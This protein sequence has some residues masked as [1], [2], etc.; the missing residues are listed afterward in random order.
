MPNGLILAAPAS[1][2]GKTVVALALAAALRR[3][4]KRVVPAKSGPDYIDGA[5]LAAAA[6]APCRNLDAWAMRR[7]TIAATLAA[8]GDA[9]LVLCEGAMGLFDGIGAGSIGS[10]AALAG[11]V[12]WPVVL[13]ADAA[14]VG[15]SISALVQGFAR[16]RPETR[17]GGIIL[18]RVGSA[19]HRAALEAALARDVPE[20]AYLGAL[21]R[22]AA[23]ALPSRHLG[24]V[25]ASELEALDTLIARAAEK[26]EAELDVARILALAAPATLAPEKTAPPLPPP[27]QRIAVA[28]DRAFAFAYAFVLEGWRAAGASLAFF[29][30]LADEPPD[31]ACDAVYLPGGYPELHAGTLAAARRC[32]AGLHAAAAHGARIYGECGGYMAL[33]RGLVDAAGARHEM[34]GL[35][36]LETD[37]S[38]RR[39]QLGYREARLLASSPFGAAGARYRGHE[40]HYATVREEGAGDALFALAD[41]EG[42]PLGAA[43]RVAG[44]V[45][46]S[47]VHLLD[48]A[49]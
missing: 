13:V 2:S 18:N 20:V 29:S 5:F 37:F 25:Q 44:T 24:L 34:M 4:G 9:D 15:A 10:T 32:R 31:P 45:M 33:G 49:S 7:E 41:G 19:R 36:P 22:D 47:F 39:L 27:G 14:G 1:G 28:R 12:G 16:H 23:L 3:R 30:P 43:G 11:I 35:L 48:R 46:G 8:C 42:A 26:A 40:F 38:E 6:G 17:L 21:T